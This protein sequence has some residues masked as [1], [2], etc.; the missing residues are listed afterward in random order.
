MKPN[1]CRQKQKQKTLVNPR[2]KKTNCSFYPEESI[3]C[4]S[5]GRGNSEISE[6]QEINLNHLLDTENQVTETLPAMNA[7]NKGTTKATVQGFR[8]R[9]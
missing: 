6:E 5:I 9:N 7:K 2:Q 1:F 8:R 4:G 3:S